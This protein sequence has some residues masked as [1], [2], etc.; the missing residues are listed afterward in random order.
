MSKTKNLWLCA[1]CGHKQIKWTGSCTACGSWNTLAEF[2]ETLAKQS[3]FSATQQSTKPTLL[4]DISIKGFERQL[5]GI[6][7]VDRLL[8]GGAVMGSL[9]L[10]GGEPGVGKSTLLLEL[11]RHF[12]KNG[13]KVLYISGEESCEQISLR[14]RRMKIHSEDLYIYSEIQFSKVQAAVAS[15]NPDILIIDSV[16]MLYKEDFPSAPGSVTQVKE[17][18]MEC[19]QLA[20]G[21][22][23]TT[24]LIGHVTKS[25]ELA[26]PRILEHIVDTV[27]EFEGDQKQGFRLLR[28]GKNRFGPTEDI[29]IF[30]M[31]E[32]GLKQVENPSAVFLQERSHHV[33][34]S[35]IIP[36]IEGSRSIL[37][38]AQA[39]V[40]R[41]NFATSTRKSSGLNA[42]RL[43]LLLAVLE[44]RMGYQLHAMDV[45]VSIAGGLKI[46]EPAIDL[47]VILAI[48]SSFCDQSLSLTSAVIGEVGLGGE[49]RSVARIEARIKEALNMGFTTCVIPKKNMHGIAQQNFAK[50]KIHGIDLVEEAIELLL[51]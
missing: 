19:M 42:N 31:A 18:A 36:T 25:G 39:L 13:K 51:V 3:R 50:I 15:L 24:F 2:Q 27:L 1:E 33:A 45:F 49:V 44:K 43:A 29:A 23:I 6:S 11:S 40:A 38:E 47:G 17:I 41:S 16:Q 28:S 14:A 26:G 5:T 9:T 21:R 20:K 37:I 22:G 30:Q 32:E 7:E 48:A 10:I 12:A 46:T 34:G 35:V 8:G 4:K